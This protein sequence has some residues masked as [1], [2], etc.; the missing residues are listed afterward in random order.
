MSVNLSVFVASIPTLLVIILGYCALKFDL[1]KQSSVSDINQFLVTF[2]LPALLFTLIIDLDT[3]TIDV[4][5]I[6]ISLAHRAI[7]LVFS[8]VIPVFLRK[9]PAFSS[10]PLNVFI[11]STFS[12]LV[13]LNSIIIG[14]PV[15]EILF[16][17]QSLDYLV[18]SGAL[19]SIILLPIAVLL[20]QSREDSSSVIKSLAKTFATS[21]IILSVLVGA[22]YKFFMVVFDFPFPEVLSTTLTYLAN[23]VIGGLLVVIGMSFYL[24]LN[25]DDVKSDS[26]CSFAFLSWLFF[27]RLMLSP[28]IMWILVLI[29]RPAKHIADYAI[30]SVSLPL[31]IACFSVSKRFSKAT[32][33]I[34]ILLIATHFL[35]V[36][37]LFVCSFVF[38][39][40]I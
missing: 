31:A 28:F 2:C 20:L 37:V 13:W 23:C 40:D 33:T 25:Q 10:I 15:A 39:W 4:S 11:F 21:T 1:L 36:P 14:L 3:S 27:L 29:F 8:A 34:N 30:Y 5:Y 6:Y 22:I 12:S 35:M 9:L 26:E 7:S 24:Q 17:K 38:N 16:G 19:D 32:K 18:I